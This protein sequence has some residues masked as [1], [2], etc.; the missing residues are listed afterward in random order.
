MSQAWFS[1]YA[2]G[3]LVWNVLVAL[4]GAYVRAT[5]SGAGCGSHWPTCNGEIIPRSP[6]VETLIEFTHRATSGLA[7]LS[8]L[9]LALLAFRLFP[10]GHPARL[11]SGVAFLFM[12]TESLVGASLVLFG[13]T[14]HNVSAARAVVQMVHLANTYFLLASLALTAWWASGGAP[15]R[16][17]GQGAVG[18]ALLLGLL[19][20]LFL[21][22]SG[23]VTALG[24]LLFPVR[25]TLEALERSLTPGEHFLVR[26][27]V[28]HPLIAVSVGL[29]VVFA[30]YLIAHLRPSI[31]TRRFAHALAY[32]Y[33]VQLLAGLVNVWLKAPVWMQ[34]LHLLLAYAVWLVFL[35]LSA[36]A[37]ARGARRVEL[38]EGTEAAHRGTGGATW[39]DYLALT[40]PRV[41]SLLLFTTLLAMLIAAKGWPGTG[42]FLVVALGGYMMAGAANAINMV[43]D[44]D[45]DARMR[46]TARRPTVTQ[47]ISSKGALLFAFALA[48]L[49]F[50]LLWWGANLLTATLALMGLIW[51]VLVYTL[52]LK[53]RTWQNI[54]IGGA[55]GAFPPLVGWTAVTGELSLFAWYLFALIFFWTPVHFWALALMIQDDYRA[56]GVPMLPVVLG[57]RVTVMQ[58]ALYAVLTALISLMPLLL[59]EL[60]LVYFFFSLTL[61]ALLIL[62]SLALYRQPERRTAVSLYKYSML[63]LALLFVAMAVDRVL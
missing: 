24:D 41:I 16:L 17:R 44:R 34:I 11:G 1:R 10:K 54:V 32:L 59:G 51:Y 37:L 14:A 18:A 12:I 62:K 9:F 35:L 15:L 2:W 28:L 63:Y 53:R 21:G 7:F 4:W 23:A 40:K 8:V 20:L 60:G 30:G 22:M 49:S 26:L 45:I 57:E 27:R 25:N 46:R 31:H 39:K 47:R 6:Q 13:W 5:G 55:A 3:V 19:A 33:G 50:L 43:V 56:V 42:L 38:G 52:Y 48:L 58:I 29:Y 36:A 61:N